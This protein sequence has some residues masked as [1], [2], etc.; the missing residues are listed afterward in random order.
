MS[1]FL[2]LFLS[3]G[4]WLRLSVIVRGHFSHKLADFSTFSK[5]VCVIKFLS[6]VSRSSSQFL[7]AKL[8]PTHLPRAFVPTAQTKAKQ[9]GR[10]RWTTCWGPRLRAPGRFWGIAEGEP[11]SCLSVSSG[12]FL[13]RL[14]ATIMKTG[15]LACSGCFYFQR[16]KTE[17]SLSL[18]CSVDKNDGR[19]ARA[20]LEFW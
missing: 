1:R 10:M 17:Q 16:I 13:N 4:R 15:K 9:R 20:C 3:F 7:F 2:V 6:V 8:F 5:Y 19:T 12:T 11:N 18:K 14:L